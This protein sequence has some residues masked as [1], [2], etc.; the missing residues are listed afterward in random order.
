MKEKVRK[1]FLSA[2]SPTEKG[3][4]LAD[5]L[6]FGILLGW[7]TSPLKSGIRLFSNNSWDIGNCYAD[8]EEEEFEDE[9]E[10]EE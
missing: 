9:E 7:L 6:L 2:W 10:E 3:L 4:L 8:D 5:V 1:L